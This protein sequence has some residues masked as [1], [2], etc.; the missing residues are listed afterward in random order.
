MAAGRR[1]VI[2]GV[3][4]V[5][6]TPSGSGRSGDRMTVEATLAAVRDAGLEPHEVDG[7]VKYT[8]DTAISTYALPANIGAADL[9]IA[10]EVPFGGG[11]C[12]ALTDVARGAVESGRAEVVVCTRT[13][14]GNDWI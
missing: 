1:A 9:R 8:Y 3:G 12:A 10:V 14:L 5:P 4:E 7:A 11:S 13:V 6:L 2:A